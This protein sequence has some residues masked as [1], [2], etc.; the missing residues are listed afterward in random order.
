MHL[1]LESTSS[2]AELEVVENLSGAVATVPARVWVGYTDAGIKVACYITRVA[3]EAEEDQGPFEAELA[4]Q[5]HTRS[6]PMSIPLRL[7]L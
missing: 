5:P 1:R 6:A 3:V 4:A 7:V 2:I